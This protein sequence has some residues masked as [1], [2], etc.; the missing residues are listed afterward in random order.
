VGLL[1]GKKLVIF[2]GLRQN[3]TMTQ[4]HPQLDG[5]APGMRLAVKVN[6][7]IKKKHHGNH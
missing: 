2:I 7:Q 5:F 4:S 6:L 3:R 1:I